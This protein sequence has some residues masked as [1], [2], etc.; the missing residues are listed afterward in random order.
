V[1]DDL[2]SQVGWPGG[3]VIKVNEVGFG[4][5]CSTFASASLSAEPTVTV[6]HWGW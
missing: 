2:A 4:S 1:C 3:Q 6:V 5:E